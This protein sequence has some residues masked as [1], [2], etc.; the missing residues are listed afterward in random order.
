MDITPYVDSLRRDLQAA[1]E[2][3]GPE[4]RE[5][6]ERL[7]Y[8][9]DPAVRLAVMEAISHAA[10]EITAAMADGS[11]DVRLDGRDLDF[12]VDAGLPAT[13]PT[14][15]PPAAP[16]PPVPPAGEDEGLARVSLRLPESLKNRADD[17]AAQAGQSLNT[18]LVNLIR[19]ATSE[20]AIHVDVDLSSV[21][22]GGDFPFSSKPGNR[23][24]TGWL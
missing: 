11:V 15:A 9:L 4:A 12:V 7:G 16:V 1:A 17:F 14:P 22:F 18:W 24:M 3:A 6:A 21:P 5:I 19:G 8:A 13:P 2:S 10:A 23:R 20:R